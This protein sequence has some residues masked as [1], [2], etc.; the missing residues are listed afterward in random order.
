MPLQANLLA[1]SCQ[2]GNAV[3]LK[4]EAGG[5]KRLILAPSLKAVIRY[6]ISQLRDSFETEKA[7][8]SYIPWYS[9]TKC[10]KPARN[11]FISAYYNVNSRFFK[12]NFQRFRF[13]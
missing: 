8:P 2:I 13:R 1:P 6:R 5:N 3:Y 9:G 4:I 10:L 7:G 11:R 12:T